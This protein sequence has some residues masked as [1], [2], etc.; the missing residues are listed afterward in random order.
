[1]ESDD[2]LP[3]W[4]ARTAAPLS[5]AA[6]LYLGLYATDVMWLSMPDRIKALS[7]GLQLVLWGLFVADFLVRI[8]MSG[9]PVRYLWSHPLDVLTIILPAARAL[10]ALRVFAAIRVL[11]TRGSRMDVGK[12]WGALAVAVATLAFIGALVVLEAERFDPSATI[13]TFP[14]ALWWSIVTLTTVGYGD[15][16]PVTATGQIAAAM[17]MIIGI[18]LLGTVT[19]TVAAWFAGHFQAQEHD[20]HEELMEQIVQLRAEV[21]ALAAQHAKGGQP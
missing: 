5:A 19:A 18:G 10:R 14:D 21:A 15:E 1:M 17:M 13:V 7:S 11:L 20:R 6:I 8:A 12:L 9:R 16:Y 4:E 3:R 2:R